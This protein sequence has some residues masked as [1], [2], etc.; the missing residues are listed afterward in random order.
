MRV[1]IDDPARGVATPFQDVGDNE[2]LSTVEL[3]NLGHFIAAV[4]SGNL[5]AAARQLGVTQ[6]ALTKAVRWLEESV[7]V[8]LFGRTQPRV[9][10][11]TPLPT[12]E[13]V[14]EHFR[15]P[16]PRPFRPCRLGPSPSP[17]GL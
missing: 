13:R 2:R 11:P 8:P 14:E 3:R 16:M 15:Q 12:A 1:H 9:P 6:P 17:S 5:C 7:G 10:P 4:E